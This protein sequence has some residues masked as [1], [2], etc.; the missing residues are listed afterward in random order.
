MYACLFFFFSFQ[1]WSH[2]PNTHTRQQA[3]PSILAQQARPSI[4][5]DKSVTL[6]MYWLQIGQT[7]DAQTWV[8]Q[9][10][11]SNATVF[12]LELETKGLWQH[13]GRKGKL[14][15]YMGRYDGFTLKKKIRDSTIRDW[16]NTSSTLEHASVLSACQVQT[17]KGSVPS[18]RHRNPF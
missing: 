4:L 1:A 2:I 16:R 8:V 17:Q 10:Y 11:A 6:L 9:G 12:C 5:A 14:H 13:A 3:R 18:L 15:T 7:A